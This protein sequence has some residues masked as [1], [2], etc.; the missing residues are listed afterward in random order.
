VQR[1]S[2]PE[3]ALGSGNCPTSG[4]ASYVVRAFTALLAQ[5]CE[6]SRAVRD[7]GVR[8]PVGGSPVRPARPSEARVPLEER[9][10]PVRHAL[11]LSGMVAARGEPRHRRQETW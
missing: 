9:E 1:T 3:T 2:S 8:G 7:E 5:T 10:A 11:L 6:R 4:A